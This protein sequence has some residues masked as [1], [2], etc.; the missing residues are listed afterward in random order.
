MA[1]EFEGL[2]FAYD[3]GKPLFSG[4]SARFER[5]KI[6][7]LTGAS[8]GG[9]STLLYLAA[10]LYPGAAGAVLSGGVRVEGRSPGE[11]P[12]PERCRLAGMMFQ[13]PSLQFCLDTPARELTFCLENIETP[14]SDIPADA[15][16][17]LAFCGIGA[18]RGRSLLS[19][20][21]GERQKVALAC[22][23]A[24]R[25]RWLLLDE[26]FA[27]ID[28]ASAHA[29]AAK[30]RELHDRFGTGILAVDHRLDNWLG[31]ADE[32]RFLDGGA[33]LP[34]AMD[35]ARPDAARLEDLGVI[36]PGRPYL[37]P[38]PPRRPAGNPVLELR[39]LTVS[40]GKRPSSPA[41]TPASTRAASTRSS[42]RAAVANPRCSARSRACTAFRAKSCWTA[43]RSGG[44]RPA[45]WAL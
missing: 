22:L 31:I 5:E 20:S 41:R 2:T 43:S 10:G 24:L 19:L 40:H 29:I 35:A 6:T 42:A 34:E 15:D 28:D 25:P 17:A 4:L 8:G 37:S 36:V 1:I 27:N 26:P 16:A 33:V 9:K 11:L 32:I 23:T 45:R 39:G 13:D 21:G 7:V 3:G 30:L 14:P 18:L 12:P 44:A 38:R